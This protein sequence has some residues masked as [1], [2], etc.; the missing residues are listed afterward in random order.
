MSRKPPRQVA[1]PPQAGA[2]PRLSCV[3]AS[4]LPASPRLCRTSQ[5]PSL[6][7]VIEVPCAG[8]YHGQA[9]FVGAGDDVVAEVERCI[10][11]GKDCPGYFMCISGHFPPNIPVENALYYYDVYCELSRR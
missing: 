9:E 6:L 3:Q 1:D 10:N 7:L 8:E 11:L 5:A 4:G 2:R